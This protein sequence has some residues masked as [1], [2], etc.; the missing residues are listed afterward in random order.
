MP[1]LK[2]SDTVIFTTFDELLEFLA[3]YGKEMANFV[4]LRPDECELDWRD[5]PTTVEDFLELNGH[6]LAWWFKSAIEG[7]AQ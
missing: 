4:Y 5:V 3:N 1:Q 7:T 2:R 6:E